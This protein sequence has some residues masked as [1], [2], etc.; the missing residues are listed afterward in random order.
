MNLEYLTELKKNLEIDYIDTYF[1][2][3]ELQNLNLPEIEDDSFDFS[4]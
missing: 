2:F 1:E 4:R 3:E